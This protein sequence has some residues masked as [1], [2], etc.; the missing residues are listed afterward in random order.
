MVVTFSVDLQAS[1]E[2]LDSLKLLQT[3][4]DR[5]SKHQ[6]ITEEV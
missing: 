3:P 6:K 5:H 1:S 4:D 2:V